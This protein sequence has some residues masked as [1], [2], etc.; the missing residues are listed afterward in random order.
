MEEVLGLE[1]D[2]ETETGE[3]EVGPVGLD[4]ETVDEDTE[5]L[6]EMPKKD[7]PDRS[8]GRQDAR[9]L[10]PLEEEHDCSEVHSGQEHD[11]WE[12]GERVG[13]VAHTELS[14]NKDKNNY[15]LF[16]KKKD[17]ILFEKLTKKWCK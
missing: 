10:R 4:E 8:A 3:S 16:L 7:S 12:Q 13:P 11:E 15:D 14:E 1:G 6:E 2:E 5:T 17:Q 9:R